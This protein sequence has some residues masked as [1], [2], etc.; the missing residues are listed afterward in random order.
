[1]NAPLLPILLP[2]VGA[3]FCLFGWKSLGYQRVISGIVSIALPI[4][5]ICQ[6]FF[7]RAEGV[8]VVRMGMWP[9]VFGIVVTVDLL[10]AIMICLSA[11]TQCVSWFYIVAGAAKPD[12]ERFLL[13]PLFLLLGTG[14]AWAFSTGDI[15][16]LFVS[17]EIILIASYALISH[18]NEKTQ[19]REAF[20]FVVLNVVSSAVFLLSAGFAYGMFGTL[21]MAEVAVRIA[22]A[23]PTPEATL[24]GT[25]LLFVF[26]FKAALFPMF[27]WLPHSYPKAPIGVVAYFSGILTKVGV[28]CLYRIFTLIFRDPVAMSEWFQPL[29]LAIGGG[30]MLVGVL[31]ALS[32]MTFRRILSFHIISQIGYMI[33]G[34]GVFTPFALAAGIFYIIH[35]IIVKASLFL[36]A[37][38]V[39]VNEGTDNLKKVSGLLKVYP[40]LA[41]LFLLSALS[42]AGIPPLSGF[43][44]KY[45][46]IVEGLSERHYIYVAISVATGLLTLASMMKIWRLGFWGELERVDESHPKNTK[47]IYATGLLVAV[48]LFVAV[49][50]GWLFKLTTEAA[51]QLF[52]RDAYI[53]AVLGER[54]VEALRSQTASSK[55]VATGDSAWY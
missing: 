19:L 55:E 14:V 8:Q 21:N 54:G 52:S 18:S 28:Y 11:I 27:Y 13:H 26:G 47:V 10:G 1:M 22:Q 45:G 35:H 6:L 20:K 16:N 30:T 7:I 32:Q 50:S 43:Y 2:L 53:E 5:A 34:L 3:I 39:V 25:L 23:G 46:L 49:F 44:G 24:L 4:I 17:F 48:S 12:E 36:V 33:F 41:V 15:F 51:D 38:C 31:G 29:I 9:D 40:G 37:G 42:L